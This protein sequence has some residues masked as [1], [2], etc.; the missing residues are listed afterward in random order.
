MLH[1]RKIIKAIKISRANV[2]SAQRSSV[3]S[4]PMFISN[5]QRF[6][7]SR[8]SVRCPPG[9]LRAPNLP[10]ELIAAAGYEEA[11]QLL[12]QGSHGKWK[13]KFQDFSRIFQDKNHQISRTLTGISETIFKYKLIFLASSTPYSQPITPIL[14]HCAVFFC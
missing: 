6:I 1:S 8:T 12:C 14:L 4:S 10:W 9:M 5:L 11:P 13:T 2:K 3:S 7:S